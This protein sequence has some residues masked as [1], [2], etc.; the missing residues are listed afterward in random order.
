MNPAPITTAVVGATSTSREE[1]GRVFDGP[2]C[3]SPVVSGDRRA[4]RRRAHA[5]DKLVVAENGL[6][7]GDRRPGCD[8]VR[9]A[10][11]HD[12][13]VMDA[14]V[15]AEPVEELFWGLECE[16]FFLFDQ[17]T[18]EIRQAT[19]REGDVTGS[20]ENRDSRVG[21]E[22]TKTCRGRHPPGDTTDDHY[23]HRTLRFQ[24]AVATAINRGLIVTFTDGS[25]RTH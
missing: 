11:D 24:N 4:Y 5:E 8:R 10:I 16:V 13:V 23:S 2:Q 25:R 22:A 20:F 9:D 6:S 7:A 15:E 1:A 14:G 17:A 21:I 12:D 19:V 3:A 18:D